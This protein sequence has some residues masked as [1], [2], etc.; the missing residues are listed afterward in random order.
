[1]RRITVDLLNTLTCHDCGRK[2]QVQRNLIGFVHNGATGISV[3]FIFLYAQQGKQRRFYIG[4]WPKISL[5]NI[6]ADAQRV[7]ELVRDGI[8]PTCAR[9]AA[10]IK[11][12]KE[13]D[14]WFTILEEAKSDHLTMA[15]LFDVWIEDGVNRINDNKELRRVFSKDILPLIGATEIRSLSDRDILRVLRTQ[16]QRGVVKLA[17][18]TLAD[19]RQMLF[20]AEKRQPWRRLLA[21]GN[22]ALL[23]E[24]KQ[25]VPTGYQGERA[26]VLNPT[27]IYELAQIFQEM[28]SAY[29]QAFDRRV[30]RRPFSK[31]SQL[32]LW[33]CL[34]SLCRIGELLQSRWQYVDLKSGIWFIPYTTTKGKRQK[35]IVFMS[36]FVR[37]KFVKLYAITGDSEW[38]FPSRNSKKNTHICLKTITK[39][40]GDRQVM[41]K[42]RSA[43][44]KSR[45]CDNSLVL[46]KGLAGEWTP[47]D[48]RRTGAT[49]MQS[50]GVLLEVIDRCQNHVLPGSRVRRH[51]MHHEYAKETAQAWHLLGEKLTAILSEAPVM[52]NDVFMGLQHPLHQDHWAQW[53]GDQSLRLR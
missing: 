50:L 11:K 1:M 33:I 6:E 8:N 12:K 32:A 19:I 39:Q 24:K 21:N 7:Q 13:V 45:V 41:F 34:G 16:R 43:P 15:D 4:V 2:L 46:S 14:S 44:L 51:Y 36:D 29:A 3:R 35:H 38:C 31:H 27:E 52:A 25:I 10:R 26:R 48:L 9:K 47:H 22:P 40:V 18:T 42:D 28:E 53:D 17:L 20:W 37:R 30:A 23:V 49:M 5:N